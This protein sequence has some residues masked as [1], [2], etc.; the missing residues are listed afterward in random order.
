MRSDWLSPILIKE[1]RQGLRARVF[2]GSFILLQVLMVITMIVALIAQ[3]DKNMG[4]GS[5]GFST[6]LFWMMV[7][8]PTLIIMPLRGAGALR[9]EI[10]GNTLELMFLTRLSSWRI[11]VG[12][13]AALFAQTCLLVCAVLPYIVLRYF[14]GSVELVTELRALASLLGLS[15]LMTGVCVALSAFPSR[16]VRGLS[17]VVPFLM[18]WIGPGLYGMFMAMRSSGFAR[19]PGLGWMVGSFV[20]GFVALLYSFEFGAARIGPAAENHESRKRLLGLLVLLLGLGAQAAGAAEEIHYFTFALILPVCMDALCRPWRNL[21]VLGVPFLK[22][23]QLGRGLAW[24]LLPG[25]PSGL[26]YTALM[27]ALVAVLWTVSGAD[28]EPVSWIFFFGALGLLLLPLAL[29][30]NEV[31]RTDHLGATYLGVFMGVVCLGGTTLALAALY[32]A[33]HSAAWNWINEEDVL[34]V[35]MT[36]CILTAIA[37]AV[38]RGIFWV[39]LRN[40]LRRSAELLSPAPTAPV[41]EELPGLP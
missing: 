16:L 30:G 25:W 36:V 28:P 8:I 1:L 20:F 10:E 40:L 34:T 21:P 24:V 22:G 15:G 29:V 33:F 18:L 32:E 2:E 23:R 14:L 5:A 17:Y 31:L 39:E 27:F 3:A 19:G 6:G 9:G 4:S 38:R 26:L 41:N 35:V 7:G 11:V 12:K 37:L 13:W